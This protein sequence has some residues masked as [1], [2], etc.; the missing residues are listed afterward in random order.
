MKIFIHQISHRYRYQ[1][2]IYATF[3]KGTLYGVRASHPQSINAE[4]S[5]IDV[6]PLSGPGLETIDLFRLLI[7]RCN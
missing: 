1:L 3:D 6:R 4:T 5:S 7:N 2:P